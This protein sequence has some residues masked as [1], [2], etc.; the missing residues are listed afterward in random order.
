MGLLNTLRVIFMSGLLI[1]KHA[2]S[3]IQRLHLFLAAALVGVAPRRHA[4][5]KPLEIARRGALVCAQDFIVIFLGIKLAHASFAILVLRL[6]ICNGL[7]RK[8]GA[9]ARA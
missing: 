6:A 3:L 7:D 8:A 9:V 4:L 2:V 5:V 1:S